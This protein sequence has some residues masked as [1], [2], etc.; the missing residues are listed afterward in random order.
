MSSKAPHKCS[1]PGCR[2]LTVRGKCDACKAKPKYRRVVGTQRDDLVQASKMRGKRAY[3]NKR[4]MLIGLHPYCYNPI[5]LHDG[6]QPRATQVH[7]I[8][9][10]TDR[11]DM[12]DEPI[13]LVPLCGTCHSEVEKVRGIGADDPCWNRWRAWCEEFLV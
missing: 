1:S 12:F 3:R 2:N 8:E 11:P 9:K 7:H 10:I 13:N 4:D 6:R 5:G